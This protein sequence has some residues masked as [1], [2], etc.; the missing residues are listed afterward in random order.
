MTP[1]R[2]GALAEM[3]GELGFTLVVN[4]QAEA[5]HDRSARLGLAGSLEREA[6]AALICL[7]DM[8]N[9][10]AGHVATL[11]RLAD[12]ETVAMSATGEWS[13]PPTLIQQQFSTGRDWSFGAALSMI[14]MVFVLGSLL[15]GAQRRLRNG[16]P[17]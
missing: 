15:W 5:G 8:P 9:V 13:S 11:A 14:L 17:T 12:E 4:E 3:L 2:R 1:A 10:D 16:L 7:G 6:G